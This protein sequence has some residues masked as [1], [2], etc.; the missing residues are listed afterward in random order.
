[1]GSSFIRVKDENG[2]SIVFS[3]DLGN[4]PAPLVKDTEI[5]SKADYVLVESAYGGRLHENILA[6]KDALEDIIEESVKAGG[7]LMIPAFAMER[8][9]ELLFELNELVEND[10]IPKVPI[11]IDSPLAIRLTS[12]YKKY[13]QNKNYFDQ[14][15][16]DLFQ[17]NDAIFNFPGLKMTLTTEQ[18][19]EIN[20]VKPP[21]VI[22]AGSG[23]SEGGRIIHHEMRYLSDPKTATTI[24]SKT[25]DE[26][27]ENRAKYLGN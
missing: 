10:R 24:F 11:F 3:G 27:I 15:A 19:K 6:R 25:L 16:I 23:M 4:T 9:Q 7:V 8:T 5:I 18:S 14:E 17:K 1:L 2:K 26:H 22:V 21:K 13:S 20:D 12:V